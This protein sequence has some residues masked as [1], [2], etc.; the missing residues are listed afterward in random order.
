MTTIKRN[1]VISAPQLPSTVQRTQ[2]LLQTSNKN[3][4]CEAIISEVYFLVYFSVYLWIN[5]KR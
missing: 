4:N 3:V 5:R 2:L 1:L